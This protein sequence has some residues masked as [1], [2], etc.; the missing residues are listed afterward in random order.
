MLVYQ[1]IC[2]II[3][4]LFIFKYSFLHSFNKVSIATRLK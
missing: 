2:E 3:N 1:K 4:L